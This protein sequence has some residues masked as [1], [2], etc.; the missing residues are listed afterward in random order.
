[1]KQRR[2]HAQHT[3]TCTH[4]HTHLGLAIFLISVSRGRGSS[5]GTFGVSRRGHGLGLLGNVPEQHLYPRKIQRK[6]EGVK[7][8]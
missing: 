4:T 1:L 2:L 7:P 3:H 5:T 6:S 8:Q